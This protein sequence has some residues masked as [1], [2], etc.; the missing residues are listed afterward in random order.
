MDVRLDQVGTR[1]PNAALD[2]C[3]ANGKSA[4]IDLRK[5]RLYLEPL[6]LETARA[7]LS[8][9]ASSASAEL[10]FGDAGYGEGVRRQAG[11]SYAGVGPM[12]YI[13]INCN[14]Q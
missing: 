1:K 12:N 3:R 13:A 6:F 11:D 7:V 10:L 9:Q 8:I 4:L 5:Q 14:M 2:W